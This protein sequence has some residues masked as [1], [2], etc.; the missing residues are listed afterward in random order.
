MEVVDECMLLQP[1]ERG[2]TRFHK[3]HNVQ[4]ALNFLTH[5]RVGLSILATVYVVCNIIMN[6]WYLN[7]YA[8]VLGRNRSTCPVLESTPSGMGCAM[9]AVAWSVWYTLDL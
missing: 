7:Q 9:H 4:I 1:R 6:T 5:K 2:N 3:L 8:N